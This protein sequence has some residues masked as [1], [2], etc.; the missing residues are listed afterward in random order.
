[1]LAVCFCPLM[2]GK[3][4][5]WL[6]A[7]VIFDAA[8]EVALFGGAPPAPAGGAPLPLF[9]SDVIIQD[10]DCGHIRQ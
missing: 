7:D 1:M 10:V 3:I 9:N 8:R 6:K 2:C 5:C 4:T